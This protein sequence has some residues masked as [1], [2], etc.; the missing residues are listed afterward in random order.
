MITYRPQKIVIQ[1][2]SLEDDLTSEILARL[3]E[4]PPRPAA[5]RLR[6]RA[7]FHSS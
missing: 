4:I 2:D 5:L 6:A 7:Q 1:E 3:P